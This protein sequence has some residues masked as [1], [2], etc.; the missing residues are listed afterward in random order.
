M[1]LNEKEI[2]SIKKAVRTHFG[3]NAVVYLFGS[4]VDNSKR[5]GDI[6]LL[7]EHSPEVTGSEVIKKKLKT[8]TDIQFALGDRK[9]D[10][11]TVPYNS[12]NT[13]IVKNAR[14]EAIQL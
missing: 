2:Q 4:R 8:M 12:E 11:V 3:E 5:G 13:L 9:I 7:I 14:K 1:R 6:D 10:I